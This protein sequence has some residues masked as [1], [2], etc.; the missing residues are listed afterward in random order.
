MKD[1][2]DKRDGVGKSKDT[3]AVK[4][5]KTMHTLKSF[6][7]ES[8]D[9]NLNQTH[10]TPH[11]DG[12]SPVVYHFLQHLTSS[13]IGL[14]DDEISEQAR[15]I[16]GESVDAGEYINE[17]ALPGTHPDVVAAKGRKIE[18]DKE[19]AHNEENK[20]RVASGQ[21][22]VAYPGIRHRMK[23]GFH[24]AM[25]EGE[26]PDVTKQKAKESQGH[27]RKFMHEEGGHSAN[28]KLE[29]TS[30]N[31]KTA[32]STGAGQNTIGL[33][34][35]PASGKRSGEKVKGEFDSCP[36]S[37]AECRKGCLGYTAG[38]NNQ[39]K[40][41]SDRSKE[42]RKRYLIEHPE[43]AARVL[44]H[45]IGQNEKFC[46]EHSTIHDKSGGIVGYKNHK[47]G[48]VKSEVKGTSDEDVKKGL[49]SGEHHTRPL[50][51]GV[52]LNVT[53][54]LQHH[55]LHPKSFFERHKDSDFYDY[56]KNHGSV[57]D[58]DK[59][60]NYTHGLSHTGDS[61]SESNSHEVINHLRK[62]GVSAMVYQRGADQPKAKRVKVH[63]SEEGKDE[64]KIVDGDSDDNLH[65]RHESAA[66]EHDA[67]A[68]HHS[69]EAS[70]SSGDAKAAHQKLADH[71]TKTAQEYRDKKHGVV[72]GLALKG[73]TNDKAG[74]FANKVDHTGTVWLHDHGPQAKLRR[75][76]PIEKK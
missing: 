73:I 42:L 71:H 47:S 59:P 66:Q 4:E 49:D 9:Q 29:L 23:E 67:L 54:D 7:A 53:S 74:H 61:H 75:T 56:T 31:G 69:A 6:L 70:K 46:K 51:S 14:T 13:S 17:A 21:H 2:D 41:T 40:E 45:E 5:E 38:G 15:A 35:T 3:A 63:G 25:P 44:S 48:K 37:T 12:L 76:I 57:E 32:S 1:Y 26:H 52:R 58:K 68:E 22:P 11:K 36:N 10:G 16:L 18:A 39:Y 43:H 72:S 19:S 62:G 64:W 30:Q 55:R 60:K 20:K 24:A 8:A 33:S 27:F 65:T 28:N 50:K 34:I